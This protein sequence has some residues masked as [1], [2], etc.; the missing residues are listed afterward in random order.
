V[1]AI[2]EQIAL[3]RQKT[4]KDQETDEGDMSERERVTTQDA[5]EMYC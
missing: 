1:E 3:K 2:V 4:S 5:Q